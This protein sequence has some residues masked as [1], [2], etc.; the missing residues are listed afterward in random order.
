MERKEEGLARNLSNS[1]NEDVLSNAELEMATGGE[2]VPIGSDL[3][4][5]TLANCTTNNC[6]DGNC[7]NCVS[8]CGITELPE[9]AN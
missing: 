5:D 8:G 6:K 9:K 7:G 2:K 3:D 4:V 1:L